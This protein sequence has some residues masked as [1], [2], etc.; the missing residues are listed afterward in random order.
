MKVLLDVK[1]DGGG[2]ANLEVDVKSATELKQAV[3]QLLAKPGVA[4]VTMSED[5]VKSLSSG[6]ADFPFVVFEGGQQ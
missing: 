1:L 2:V 5:T 6:L 3:R 4:R